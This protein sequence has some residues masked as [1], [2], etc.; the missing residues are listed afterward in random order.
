MKILASTLSKAGGRGINQDLIG[1]MPEGSGLGCWVVADG[2]SE[3]AA[4][5]AVQ[6]I[7]ENFSANP[8]VTHDTVMRVMEWAQQSFRD[9]QISRPGTPTLRASVALVCTSGLSALW[10]H[11]G[12][13]RV[14]VFRDGEIIAQ[15]KDHSIAQA[16]V[17]AGN[18]KP[19]ELRSHKERT[20][21][22]RTLGNLGGSHPCIPESKLKLQVGDLFLLCTDGFWSYVTELEMMA[23]WCKSGGLEDWLERMEIRLLKSAPADH[24]NYSAVALTVVA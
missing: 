2:C 23:D 5:M 16:L 11:V 17:E 1:C 21:L 18:I 8:G 6:V 13:V 20:G 9:L 24:D 7:L 4:K 10:A 19:T 22:L 3:F 14:Y 15:T 12:N